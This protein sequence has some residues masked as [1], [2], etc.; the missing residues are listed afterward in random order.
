[1]AGFGQRFYYC[2]LASA[3]L[4]AFSDFVNYL[5][6]T[7][8][9]TWAALGIII[10]SLAP[11]IPN[12]LWRISL[13]LVLL[14]IQELG[15]KLRDLFEPILAPEIEARR[16]V[17]HSLYA[18]DLVSGMI[19]KVQNALEYRATP[20]L[21][22]QREAGLLASL[23][24]LLFGVQEMLACSLLIILLLSSHFFNPG[25][26]GFSQFLI[27]TLDALNFTGEMLRCGLETRFGDKRLKL[28]ILLRET[29]ISRYG[30]QT[31]PL[32]PCIIWTDENHRQ[33]IPSPDI[34][35][36]VEASPGVSSVGWSVGTFSENIGRI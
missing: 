5:R 16:S 9:P 36:G 22:W 2:Q 24:V 1:M 6:Q 14:K 27:Q 35:R 8:E 21:S 25:L 17:G 33:P 7:H 12:Y 18:A 10:I 29:E 20:I 15:C 32:A 11:S 34:Y 23:G 4:I 13:A 26:Y 31:K 28:Q 30:L 3:G 19:E